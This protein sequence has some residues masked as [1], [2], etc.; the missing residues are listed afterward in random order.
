M[1]K[2]YNSTSK[3]PTAVK[4]AFLLCA[5]FTLKILIV[6]TQVVILSDD[7]KKI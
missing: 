7:D 3:T 5:M 1:I 6:S 4:K 2:E